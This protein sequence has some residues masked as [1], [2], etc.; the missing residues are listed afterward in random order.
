MGEMG[1]RLERRVWGFRHQGLACSLPSCV[2]LLFSIFWGDGRVDS[3]S[4]SSVGRLPF[5]KEERLW[6]PSRILIWCSILHAKV[7]IDR[8]D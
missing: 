4:T 8:L 6:G 1:F 2:L 5:D 7:N 3:W